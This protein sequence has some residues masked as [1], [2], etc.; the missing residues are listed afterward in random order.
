MGNK[1]VQEEVKGW[2]MDLCFK[3][4]NRG[5]SVGTSDNPEAF[6]LG[7]GKLGCHTQKEFTISA[8]YFPW[9]VPHEGT[10]GYP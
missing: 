4:G 10:V 7:R 6:I 3:G 1:G 9:G 2:H 8:L 5:G